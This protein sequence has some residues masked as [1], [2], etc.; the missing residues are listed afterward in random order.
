[1]S[2]VD[3][4]A[5][6]QYVLNQIGTFASE[7]T[8]IT[9]LFLL[10]KDWPKV[11]DP[12]LGFQILNYDD[13]GWAYDGGYDENGHLINYVGFRIVVEIM[14][15]RGNPLATLA[16]LNH[17]FRGYKD[18][19]YKHLYSKG[20]GFLECTNPSRA[21]TVLDGIETE[22]RARMTAI[23]H[24]T[25]QDIDPTVVNTIDLVV[26]NGNQIY[27]P[28]FFIELSNNIYEYTN[29]TLPDEPD[30]TWNNLWS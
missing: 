5:L 11:S 14:A 10:N 26:V 8:G 15:I 24:A 25:V 16:Q 29:F 2:F 21:D 20:I 19:R 4:A 6:E 9:K 28:E 7:S 27:K 13:D 17:A 23:F 12:Y 22:Q 18:L 1:L 3:Y 30:A